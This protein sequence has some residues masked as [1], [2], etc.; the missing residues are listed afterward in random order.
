M[1]VVV[2]Q[3]ENNG[4]VTFQHQLCSTK[5]LIH[6][7]FFSTILDT[8]LSHIGTG[9]TQPEFDI[10]LNTLTPV[11]PYNS[12]QVHQSVTSVTAVLFNRIYGTI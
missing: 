1:V 9:S 10:G 8:H 6:K 5:T 3:S 11:F 7:T 2:G 4:G 12:V